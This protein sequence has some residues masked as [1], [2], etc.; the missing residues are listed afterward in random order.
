MED[1][2][3]ADLASGEAEPSLTHRELQS[4]EVP[5]ICTLESVSSWLQHPPSLPGLGLNPRHLQVRQP[6][7]RSWGELLELHP[8]QV[9]NSYSWWWENSVYSQGHPE[10]GLLLYVQ[11]HR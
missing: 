1:G 2:W 3:R 11:L 9:E 4:T 5:S 8:K 7:G 10:L 6:L